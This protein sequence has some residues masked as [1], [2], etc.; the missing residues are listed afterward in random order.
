M[1]RFLIS[2]I[3]TLALLATTTAPEVEAG[4]ARVVVRGIDSIVRGVVD[5]VSPSRRLSRLQDEWRHWP[6]NHHPLEDFRER[7]RL[8]AYKDRLLES[9][10]LG[11]NRKDIPS[12]L[13]SFSIEATQRKEQN[14]DDVQW[15]VDHVWSDARETSR[16]S[17]GSKRCL[18]EQMRYILSPKQIE[19]MTLLHV[20]GMTQIEA[21]E[22]LNCRRQTIAARAKSVKTEAVQRRLHRAYLQCVSH[23]RGASAR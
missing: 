18:S 1:K 23:Q 15:L 16:L 3:A 2:V 17:R 22:A 19:V 5:S 6:L 20:H 12:I 10:R 11:R 13:S 21:A 8:E 9:I 7:E 4:G 14:L